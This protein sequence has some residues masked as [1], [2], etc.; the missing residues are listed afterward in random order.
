MKGAPK[1]AKILL[2]WIIRILEIER[3]LLIKDTN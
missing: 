2:N 3:R 1:I